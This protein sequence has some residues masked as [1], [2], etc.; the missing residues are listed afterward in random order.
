MVELHGVISTG[1]IVVDVVDVV[2]VDVVD[3]VDVD[4]VVG[5]ESVMHEPPTHVTPTSHASKH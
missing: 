4:V 5:H 3:V 1:G 2:D